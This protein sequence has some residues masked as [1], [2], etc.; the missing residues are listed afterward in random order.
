[1]PPA[2]EDFFGAAAFLAGAAFFAGAAFLGILEPF[3]VFFIGFFM[4]TSP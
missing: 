4:S 2:F 1:M 3:E